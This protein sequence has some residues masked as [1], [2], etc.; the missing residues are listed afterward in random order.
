[1][2]VLVMAWRCWFFTP[3]PCVLV[4]FPNACRHGVVMLLLHTFRYWVR[5]P[6]GMVALT[7]A[8]NTLVRLVGEWP[9]GASDL[10]RC[11]PSICKPSP[12]CSDTVIFSIRMS[13]GREWCCRYMG[14]TRQMSRRRFSYAHNQIMSVS[15]S[16][17]NCIISVINHTCLLPQVVINRFIKDLEYS[18]L[19]VQWQNHIC[20]KKR[21]CQPSLQGAVEC[22][23][24]T[25]IVFL[26]YAFDLSRPRR[27][28]KALA[29]QILMALFS[30]FE[31]LA[32]FFCHW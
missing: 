20:C 28:V 13:I 31:P 5:R 14:S 24:G 10:T 7:L 8:R 17:G 30:G 9:V 6:F 16:R 23:T 25:H 15:K 18:I 2:G 26:N 4:V 27:V 29:V 22:G 21:W 32:H 1:M 19:L 11:R 3:V 12:Y